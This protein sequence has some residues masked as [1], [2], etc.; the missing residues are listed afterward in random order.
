LAFDWSSR[1]THRFAG[2]DRHYIN[3]VQVAFLLDREAVPEPIQ[4]LLGVRSSVNRDFT[5]AVGQRIY[6]PADK[7]RGDPDPLDRPYAGW[8]YAMA[9]IC[10][11]KG[12]AQDFVQASGGIVGPG[13]L[14]KHTQDLFHRSIGLDAANGW[15]AQLKNEPALLFGFERVWPSILRLPLGRFEADLTAAQ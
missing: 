2:F 8:L 5:F 12:N 11:H 1:C 3:G 13:S 10:T 7:T 14:A 6:T 4:R 9:D 15:H